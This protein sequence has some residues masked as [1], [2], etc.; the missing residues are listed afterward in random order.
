M[1]LY[2]FCSLNRSNKHIIE[3]MYLL[4]K[5]ISYM[6]KYEYVYCILALEMHN[7]ENLQK[8][9]NVCNGLS[10]CFVLLK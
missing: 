4:A 7:S 1:I 9:V 10:F 6:Y 5:R 3:K 2:Y 8:C